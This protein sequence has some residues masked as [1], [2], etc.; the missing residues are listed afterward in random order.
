MM[1]KILRT[2]SI[3]IPL[4]IFVAFTFFIVDETTDWIHKMI[5]PSQ[6]TAPPTAW[7]N[8][9]SREDVMY[10][11]ELAVSILETKGEAGLNEVGK[12]RFCEDNY[13]F[14]TDLEG[15]CLM[16]ISP[17]LIGKSLRHLKDD[18]GKYFF[19]EFKKVAKNYGCGWVD[20]RWP[21]PGTTSPFLD[22][23]SYIKACKMGDKD[24]Y[25]GAS[26]YF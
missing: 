20:Y 9:C 14:V 13:I 12:I 21:A 23:T 19:A 6:F 26:I 7:A 3:T 10:E 1:R 17:Q 25:V 22:K 15:V 24:I 18:R 16:H 4:I 8:I 2:L 5:S 11:I